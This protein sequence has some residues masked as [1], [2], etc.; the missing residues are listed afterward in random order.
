MKLT[1]IGL[2]TMETMA[3][4]AAHQEAA[5]LGVLLKE[6]P[7]PLR[8]ELDEA[9]GAYAAALLEAGFLAGLELGRNPWPV[10]V[11]GAARP[12]D[13]VLMA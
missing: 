1:D 6:L 13:P 4:R 8:F 2:Q 12:I 3:G 5:A 10:F 9:I 11:E 7:K